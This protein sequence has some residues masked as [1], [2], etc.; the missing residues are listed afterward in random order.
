MP[1]PK[2]PQ[3]R[4]SAT[5]LTIGAD[6]RKAKVTPSGTPASTKPMKSGTAEQEQKGVMMPKAGRGR[7]PHDD[8]AAGQRAAHALG[9]DE[10]AQE[11]HQRDD[12]DEQQQHLGQVEQEEG[13]RGAEAARGVEAQHVGDEPVDGRR[14]QDPGHEPGRDSDRHDQ[15]EGRMDAPRHQGRHPSTS[16]RAPAASLMAASSRS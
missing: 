8:V 13:E 2:S 9:R 1:G 12:A 4:T 7:S 15:P 5:S 14:E 11:A 3:S 10:G 16:R 6:T